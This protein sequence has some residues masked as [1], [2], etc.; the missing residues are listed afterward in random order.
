MTTTA[1]PKITILLSEGS[2]TNA[3]EVISAL[4]PLGYVLE[5]CDPNPRTGVGH[6]LAR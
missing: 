4:G 1:A 2:S 3:R 6:Q 5:V